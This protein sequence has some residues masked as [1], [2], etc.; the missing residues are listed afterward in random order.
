VSW[1]GMVFPLI[2]LA[3]FAGESWRAAHAAG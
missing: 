3:L 1:I 2:A